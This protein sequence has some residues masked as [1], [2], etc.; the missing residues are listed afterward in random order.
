MIHIYVKKLNY[1]S[2]IIKADGV[3]NYKSIAILEEVLTRNKNYKKI[4]LQL[5]KIS[6]FDRSGKDF[7]R[8]YR[9]KVIMEGI[10]D[11]L[12]AEININI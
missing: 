12:R 1:N 4:F 8:V 3:L 9:N 5:G 7:L 6:H 2:V 11:F 10:P